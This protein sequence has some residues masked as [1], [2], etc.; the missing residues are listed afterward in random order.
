MS[1]HMGRLTK[2]K[3]L[4]SIR[5]EKHKKMAYKMRQAKPSRQSRVHLFKWTPRTCRKERDFMKY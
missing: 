3:T 2:M 4:N 1:R 5:M